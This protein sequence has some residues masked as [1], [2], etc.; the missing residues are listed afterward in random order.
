[1]NELYRTLNVEKNATPEEIKKAYRMKARE[2]HPDIG[3]DSNEFIR[4]NKAYFILS[5]PALRAQ[6]DDTGQCHVESD[7][8]RIKKGAV[9]ELMAMISTIIE[10]H[11]NDPEFFYKDLIHVAKDH[12][13]TKTKEFK[14]NIKTSKATIKNLE[15]LKGRLV[16]TG[17]KNDLITSLVAQKIS[18]MKLVINI[19]KER[20]EMGKVM[21]D[22]LKDYKFN[23]KQSVMSSRYTT[24]TVSTEG[25]GSTVFGATS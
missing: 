13:N 25:M 16:Y 4:I 10:K 11:V 21:L 5:R 8:E 15:E 9:G 20:V 7:E 17:E 2:S 6:Y 22:I 3:G 18:D 12:I 19:N 1:M 23:P 14:Q 24:Y